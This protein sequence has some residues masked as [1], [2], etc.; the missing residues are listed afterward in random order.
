MYSS[1][2]VTALKATGI[3]VA[4]FGWEKDRFP[5]GNYIVYA[6][7]SAS[8]LEANGLHIER[9]TEGFVDLFT[10][11]YS[12]TQKDLV[13]SVFESRTDIVWHLDTIQFEEETKYAHYSW[14]VG[15]YGKGSTV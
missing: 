10:R 15:Q 11:D 7:D 3:P 5:S 9:A 8:D 4:H 6:E 13:E 12:T 1:D 2:F 14:M